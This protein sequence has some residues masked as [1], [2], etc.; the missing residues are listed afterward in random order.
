MRELLKRLDR[1]EEQHEPQAAE[2]RCIVQLIGAKDGKA[3][4]WEPSWAQDRSDHQRSITSAPGE[5]IEAFEAR[6]LAE[7]PKS[8]IIGCDPIPEDVR[9][10]RSPA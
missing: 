6:A 2:W 5:S 7:F 8:A 1:L 4:P 3:L 9:A 10:A